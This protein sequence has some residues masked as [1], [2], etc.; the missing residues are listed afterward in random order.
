[1]MESDAV[2]FLEWIIDLAIRRREARIQWNTLQLGGI[3]ASNVD[4]CALFHVAEIEGISAAALMGNHRW[5]HMADKSPLSLA[6]ERMGFHVR[7]AC[8]GPKTLQFVFDQQ[9]AD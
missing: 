5:L 2:E 6:E 3:G 8:S 9:L 7:G 1:M 4:A